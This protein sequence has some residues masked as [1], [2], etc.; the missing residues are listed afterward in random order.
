MKKELYL[1]IRMFQAIVGYLSEDGTW[2]ARKLGREHTSENPAEVERLYSEHPTSERDSILRMDRLLGQLM[3]LRAFGDFRFK[4]PR[5]VLEKWVSPIVGENALPQNYKTPPYLT[6]RPEIVRYTL[7]PRD[8]FLV[9]ASD[10]LWDLLSP[11]QVARLVSSLNF[12]SQ[13][14]MNVANN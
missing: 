4:W 10:G 9:M 8:K 12:K 11:T 7:N 3:P 13:I 1:N 14:F 5:H 6:A 2:G